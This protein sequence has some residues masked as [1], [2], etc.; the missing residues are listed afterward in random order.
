MGK[1]EQLT[2]TILKEEHIP[3]F[4]ISEILARRSTTKRFWPEIA[5]LT[6]FKGSAK[7]GGWVRRDRGYLNAHW[8]PV[9]H[10]RR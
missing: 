10:L 6:S 7:Y 3:H 9:E 5:V 2:K 1:F 4:L 8:A